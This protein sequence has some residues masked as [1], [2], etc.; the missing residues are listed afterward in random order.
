M[1][2]KSKKNGLRHSNQHK[3]NEYHLLHKYRY[4]EAT[5]NDGRQK[6]ENFSSTIQR[7]RREVQSRAWLPISCSRSTKEGKRLHEKKRLDMRIIQRASAPASIAFDDPHI[8]PGV[9]DLHRLHPQVVSIGDF[10]QLH[11]VSGYRCRSNLVRSRG[12]RAIVGVQGFPLGIRAEDLLCPGLIFWAVEGKKQAG[13]LPARTDIVNAWRITRLLHSLS[14]QSPQKGL[15]MA[16]FAAPD[17]G[18]SHVI[19]VTP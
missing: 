13:L 1:V 11:Q 5:T 2:S 7:H 15:R 12:C 18:G 10:Q 16:V 19:V 6:I 3:R 17:L 9:T 4:L 8:F 14:Q